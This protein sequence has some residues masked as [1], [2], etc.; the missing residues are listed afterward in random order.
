MTATTFERCLKDPRW[1]LVVLIVALSIYLL[2]RV[3]V[4][5]QMLPGTVAPI[6]WGVI[7][8]SIQPGHD[9]PELAVMVLL[10]TLLGCTWPV[11]VLLSPGVAFPPLPL[12][13]ITP[14]AHTW[15]ELAVR[16][17]VGSLGMVLAID[18]V[19][20]PLLALC[21]RACVLELPSAVF[22]LLVLLAQAIWIPIWILLWTQPRPVGVIGV[23]VGWLGA[24]LG[25]YLINRWGVA[26]GRLVSIALGHLWTTLG[27]LGMA[28][29]NDWLQARLPGT[30]KQAG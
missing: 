30:S 2:L 15:R 1:W 8:P 27:L 22:I 11:L 13:E 26:H 24:I 9:Y 19:L 17:V 7:P 29:L 14:I 18:V 21:I 6:A 23:T 16:Q 10:T 4:L 3:P 5:D 25:I 28:I 20:A 12:E